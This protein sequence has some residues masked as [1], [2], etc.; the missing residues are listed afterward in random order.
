MSWDIFPK[1]VIQYFLQKLK[2]IF[3]KK[4]QDTTLAGT[5]ETETTTTASKAHAKDSKFYLASTQQYCMAKTNIAIGDTLV[6]NTNYVAITINGFLTDLEAY[7]ILAGQMLDSKADKVSSA[8]N[9]N[10]AGLNGTGNLT[11]S[12]WNGAKDTTSISGNPISIPNLKANQLAKNPIITLEPIQDLHG[13]SKP[14]P[15]GGGKNKLNV[16]DTSLSEAGWLITNAQVALPAGTYT[17]SCNLSGTGATGQFQLFHNGTVISQ[18][19]FNFI[20]GLTTCTFTISES[21]DTLNIWSNAIGSF[22]K[23]QIESGENYTSYAP[24]E[25]ICPISGYDKVEA[26]SCGINAWDEVVTKGYYWGGTVGSAISKT[27]HSSRSCNTNPIPVIS[28]A[29]YYFY[30][31]SS[32]SVY[33]WFTDANG[34]VLSSSET[35]L[36]LPQLFTIPNYACQLYF[37]FSANIDYTS[38]ISVNYPASQTTYVPY[39]KATSISESLGQTVYWGRWKPR[40]GEFEVLGVEADMG[41]F[42]WGANGS[43]KFYTNLPLARTI[44]YI[45]QIYSDI[46]KT[47]QTDYANMDDY[48][49]VLQRNLVQSNQMG[50][51]VYDSRYTDA[52]VFKTAV[53]GQKFVYPLATPFTIQLTPHE[54]SL[55]KDYAYVSTNGTNISLDYHNGELAS[56]SDVSQLGETVNKAIEFAKTY[57]SPV[58][59]LKIHEPLVT[60]M[61]FFKPIWAEPF[62]HQQICDALVC[63]NGTNTFEYS[64]S[65]RWEGDGTTLK[66]YETINGSPSDYLTAEVLW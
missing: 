20:N 37:T 3:D 5:S 49:I 18:P 14:Y 22:S 25:N 56:L 59:M 48:C 30:G 10:L 50:V 63:N 40:T 15:A 26:L 35:W 19:A 1:S 57:H 65:F 34:I 46:Y 60:G 42:T 7:L 47:S 12:G 62:Y 51:G 58:H 29:T 39:H 66:S 2:A 13:Q 11:D 64:Y 8:T 23:F 36:T 52:T 43:G 38:G 32:Y 44:E 41:D 28:G 45:D 61:D 33:L 16:A 21:V 24:Y 31:S 54:I 9:G 4:L 6:E 55:L 53:T 27:S 17:F